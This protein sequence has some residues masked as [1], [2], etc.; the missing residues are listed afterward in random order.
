MKDPLISVN[1]C[2]QCGTKKEECPYPGAFNSAHDGSMAPHIA[3]AEFKQA[4]YDFR[5][6]NKTMR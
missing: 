3:C 2:N 5:K 6:G 4:V 1:F